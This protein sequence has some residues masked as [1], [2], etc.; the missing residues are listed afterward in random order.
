MNRPVYPQGVARLK[1]NTLSAALIA[2]AFAAP[3]SLTFAGESLSGLSLIPWP[4][5]V[6][7]APGRMVLGAQNR[8]VI[9]DPTLAPLAEVLGGEIRA[10]TGLWLEATRA[11]PSPGDIVLSLDPGLQNEAHRVAVSDIATVAGGNYGAV[12]LGTVTLL[13]ALEVKDGRVTLARLKV[14]DEPQSAYRGLLVDV[15]RQ[16]HSPENLKQMIKLCRFYKV[17]YLQLHL[18]DDQSFMFPS[19]TY[20][21]LATKN[22]HGGRTYTVEELTD[23][24]AYADAR[25]VTLIPEYEVPGHSAAANRAL[26]DLFLIKG[27]KPYEH[28]ASIN[29][30][31]P[32]V[33]QAV[34]TIV[35]EMCEVFKSSPYFHIG[36]DEADLAF[37]HQNADFK[38]AFQKHNLPN[39]HQLYR[40]FV[41]DMNELV[42]K[43]GKQMMV[44][45]GFGR[46]PNSPVPIPKDIIVMAYEIAFYMP[47]ALVRDG[48]QVVNASWTPLYVVNRGRP[49]QEIYAWHL[50]QFKPFGAKA[51][52]RGVLAPPGAGV[53]G[54]QM[55]AWEQSEAV[56]LPNERTR[57]PAV[58]E[59]IWNP[60]AGKTYADFAARL[61]AT[62]RQLDFLVHQFSVHAKGLTQPEESQFDRALTITLLPAPPFKGTIRFA[63]DGKE[64]TTNSAPYVGPI[65]LTATTPFKARA[66]GADGQPA[67]YPRAA[68]YRFCPVTGDAQNVLADDR[69]GEPALLTLRS[70]VNGDIRYTLDGK[71]P[72]TN[73]LL[74]IGPVRLEKSAAVR[75]GL[76]VDGQ[77]RGEVWGRNFTWVNYEQNLT[78]GKPVKASAVE[79]GFV[80]ENAVDGMVDL[81]SAWW[82]GPYPQWLQVDLEKVRRL[83][84]VHLFPYWGGGRSYQYTVELSVD[85][86]TWG[87]VV[88]ASR[89]TKPSTPQGDV[90]SF[91]PTAG[92]YLRVN[93]LKN[94]ANEGVHLVEI[95][96]YEARP[97]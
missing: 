86:K 87:T 12:A 46:E 80:A 65:H 6:A 90:H 18:T 31:K 5:S 23:L 24:V 85:G 45:E 84:R 82:A 13:Q 72:T 77:R 47:D 3:T 36:G 76:F 4:K 21:Q 71:D 29:F 28:H 83:D 10:V 26:P 33:M 40:K 59:R 62:D 49:P 69:F 32:E 78:T 30:A 81:N 75:A 1:R 63:V 14:T 53:I 58:L 17:R 34:A 64:P 60:T 56:E 43:H 42:K 88:D 61:E 20:P 50:H 74:Y 95:R 2:L 96:A 19:R 51:A 16:Y 68:T 54:A 25:H 9:G 37:A 8:I 27:T 94:S 97:K 41:V 67:G 73:S 79:A 92:R 48:Y 35:G 57:L 7:V 38:A 44:W 15:A 55:C 89:N 66:F 39:Q 93:M 52:A 91:A 22:Q 70:A 11:K